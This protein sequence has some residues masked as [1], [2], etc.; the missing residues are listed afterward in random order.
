MTDD[1]EEN[2]VSL[3]TAEE[4]RGTDGA[5]RDLALKQPGTYRP[6]KDEV[7]RKFFG[8]AS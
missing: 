8:S 1:G 4:I 5:E 6:N 2:Q 7:R 3:M